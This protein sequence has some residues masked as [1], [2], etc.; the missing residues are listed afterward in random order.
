[1][2]FSCTAAIANEGYTEAIIN[3]GFNNYA[4]NSEFDYA[5]GA[6]G[7]RIVEENG[8]KSLLLIADEDGASIEM[9][10]AIPKTFIISMDIEA[11]EFPSDAV[12][13][14]LADSAGNKTVIVQAENGETLLGDGKKTKS[15]L[16]KNKKV[17]L[18]YKIDLNKKRFTL[19]ADGK[20][21][22]SDW[23]IS[24]N[25]AVKLSLEFNG[26]KLMPAKIKI[27]NLRLY[28]GGT[29]KNNFAPVE[30]NSEETFFDPDYVEEEK[31]EVFA[32]NTFDKAAD[33]S[34]AGISYDLK[35]VNK[36]ELIKNGE[37][38]Y[39]Q[40]KRQDSDPNINF[41]VKPNSKNYI[42]QADFMISE[43][44]ASALLF[45][46]RDDNAQFNQL[47]GLNGSGALTTP[48]GG[49]IGNA[50]KKQW[51][52]LSCAVN[53]KKQTYDAYINGQL[54]MEK[55]S[56][57]NTAFTTPSTVRF[58][59]AGGA[60]NS[61]VAIDNFYVY[62]GSTIQT[63]FD[64]VK[65]S[66]VYSDNE[67]A[68]KKLKGTTAFMV[69]NGAAFIKDEK[70]FLDNKPFAEDKRLW[71]PGE[72][73]EKA[74]GAVIKKE[75][76]K[77]Y[78]N[79]IAV[80]FKEKDGILY[81]AFDSVAENA[82]KLNYFTD[83]E[84]G[85]AIMGNKNF[86]VYKNTA[87]DYNGNN[88]LVLSRGEKEY[89]DPMYYLLYERPSTE[90]II[91]K[92]K[93]TSKGQHP[94]IMG[95][96]ADFDRIREEIKTDPIK[97]KWAETWIKNADS[98]VGN[99]TMPVYELY[100][101]E[102]LATPSL[103]RFWKLAFAYQLT[104]DGKYCDDMYKEIL[105]LRDFPDWH[106]NHF[107]DTASNSA[108]VAVAYDWCYDYW[109]EEQKE[110]IRDALYRHGLKTGYNDLFGGAT[111]KWTAWNNNWAAVCWGSL[112]LA[113]IALMDD[114]EQE[115]ATVLDGGLRGIGYMLPMFAP[116]GAW[117]EGSGYWSYCVTWFTR[118]MATLESA[119][120]T[121]FG[122][123]DQKGVRGTMLYIYALNGSCG[124]F[125]FHDAAASNGVNA[126][127]NAYLSYRFNDDDIKHLRMYEL[128][129]KASGS[130]EDFFFT[131]T[132]Y[133]PLVP[134]SLPLDL[135]YGLTETGVMRSAW[136]ERGAAFAGYHCSPNSPVHRNF[137]SGTFIFDSMGVR[138]ATELG[139]D[140]Y[141]IPGYWNTENNPVYRV[142]TEGQN[143]YVINPGKGSGQRFESEDKIIKTESKPRGAYGVMD[144]TDAYKDDVTKAARGVMLGDNR[145]SMTVR[146]EIDF[147]KES[148][149][150]W[151]MHTSAGVDIIDNN[152]AI[153]SSGTQMKFELISNQPLTLDVMDAVP[154][155]SEVSP[156]NAENNGIRKIVIK[157]KVKGR[158]NLT[159]K[160]IPMILDAADTVQDTPISEWSIPD[161]NIPE[162]PQLTGIY[163]NGSIVS[164]FNPTTSSYIL[165]KAETEAYPEV[166]ATCGENA[167]VTV[168]NSG[169]GIYS[170]K[171]TDNNDPANAAGYGMIIKNSI[172]TLG[173]ENMK[174]LIPVEY[175]ASAEPEAANPASNI[176]DADANTRW[177]ADGTPTMTYTFEKP[178]K[179]SAVALAF[180][181]GSKRK[182][183]FEIQVSDDGENFT[184]VKDCA[185]SGTTED[186]ELYMLDTPVESKYVRILGKGND[187]SEWFSPTEFYVFSD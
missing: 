184:T 142:R 143:C 146:D 79:D 134:D 36:M 161:G 6:Y 166:T 180:Y 24:I 67:S 167:Y 10:A 2:I 65:L 175:A 141:V 69:F 53:T 148:D 174:I 74:Y 160:M 13:L 155:N 145:Q 26:T 178:E 150:Y 165:L 21:R 33:I 8:D 128:K 95:K 84:R 49:I 131:D 58:T 85:F 157:G 106:P 129:D 154:L 16:V 56:F 12:F 120:G 73:Y 34:T 25:N 23:R 94:R 104:G 89:L 64:D 9:T 15:F 51:F 72:L 187:I 101:G 39:I 107:L 48:K 76:E 88:Y 80:D 68:I 116:D 182:T 3:E 35:A 5:A 105:V 20:I 152:T 115:A 126:Y 87:T 54:V 78:V 119:L 118:Y 136:F 183:Y 181:S 168:N 98:I 125:N 18:I 93:E 71:A 186:M 70:V 185:A 176:M 11:E 147:K 140:S 19:L 4:T 32:A 27:D 169:D 42:I 156:Q 109:T 47:V 164:G 133:Q 83:V 46:L 7:T 31:H 75:G 163:T 121:D 63:D 122:Y 162:K 66:M 96:K 81:L 123:L 14:S 60:A 153:L 28:E 99:H 82:I 29:V 135:K 171:V 170:I 59:Y 124:L 22:V 144:I 103:D 57:A 1:M 138:W 108:A 97:K 173:T 38:K 17:S 45:H 151:F 114:Y 62:S 139:A 91:E 149:F 90:T 112:S 102:R 40:I 41:V 127:P 50:V 179:I 86:S 158:L 77:A 55:I 61:T 130:I 37:N 100:D 43:F 30:Y 113:A 132:S 110:A 137:D 44:G 172:N 159:V 92:Y 111:N 177:S 52:T 117:A